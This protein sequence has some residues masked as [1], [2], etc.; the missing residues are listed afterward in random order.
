M[1]TNKLKRFAQDARKKLLEQVAA[2]LEYVLNNDTA[3]L[4]EKAAQVSALKEEL[5]KTRKAQLIERVAYTWFNRLIALRFMDVNGY[6]A[7]DIRIITPKEGHS[8]PELL[9]DAKQ[10]HI[11]EDLKVNTK[12]VFDLLD[13][14]VPSANPQNEAYRMLLIAACNHLHIVLPFLFERINDYT[15]L[16]LPDDLTSEFSI[17]HDAREGMSAEDCQQVEII[18]WLYQFYISEKKDEVFASKAKV[19]KE[20]I[21]AATQLFTPRWIVE[22]MVQNT[23]GKL[24]L[25]NRSNS[26]LRKHMPYFIESA[27][28][29]SEEYL[30]LSSPQELTL[31]DQ[32]CGSGHILV[33]GFELLYRIYEEEGYNPSEIPQ[34]ILAHNLYGFEI[35]E[36]AAQ[37]A[38]MALMMKARSYQRRFFKKGQ[39]PQPHI[40]CFQDLKLDDKQLGT[41]LTSL[42]VKLSDE[43]RHDLGNMRQATNFGSL[44]VPHGGSSEIHT[45]LAT[46]KVQQQPEQADLF[47]QYELLQLKF[48]LQQLQLL[49]K[50][51]ASIVDNPPYMGGGNMDAELSDFVKR[52]YPNSKA[53]LMACFMESGLAMLQPKGFL[54]LV[55]QQSWMFLESYN[56]LRCNIID[57]YFIDTLIQIGFNSFPEL[58][59]KVVQACS[60]V[61]QNE[62]NN[63]R[64]GIY[65][66]L[67]DVEQ[68]ANKKNVFENKLKQNQIYT[69]NQKRFRNIPG[70]PIGYWLNEQVLQV[71]NN[72]KLRKELNS[73]GQLLTGNN[74]RFIR[75][76]WEVAQN[77]I[78]SESDWKLHHKGGEFRKWYGNVSWV[79]KWDKKTRDFYKQNKTA[80]IPK[81][82]LWDLEGITWST[83]T[84]SDVSFRKVLSSESFNKAAPTLVTKNPRI[85]DYIMPILNSK[86]TKYILAVYNPTLN[87]LVQDVENIPIQNNLITNDI[88]KNLYQGC[89]NCSKEEWNSKETS[90]EFTKNELTRIKG[91]DIEQ[92]FD[93]YQL[94]W[95][96]KFFQLHKNEEEINRIVINAYN[97]QNELTPKVELKDVTILQGETSIANGELVFNSD[98]VMAQFVSYAVGCMFGRYSLDVPGLVLANQAETLQ[99]YLRKLEK[100]ELEVS[101][102]PDADNI[103]PVLDDEWFEDDVVGR[104]YEFMK[105]TFGEATF[106]K[107][108]AFVEEC[109]GKDIRKYFVKD[110]YNDHIQRYKKRPI[111][112]LF[113][114]PQGSFNVLIYLHRYT[115]DTVSN[116]LN[117]YLREYQEKLR[118]RREHLVRVEVSGSASEKAK[119]TKEKAR[120]DNVL[121]ELQEYERNIL[122]PLA[123]ERLVLD[124]DNGVLV[125]YNKFGKA[126]K[127]VPGLNDEKAKKQVSEFD[128]VEAEEIV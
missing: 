35:D 80:R 126:I 55:N 17:V 77:R 90:W 97:L 6:Q 40:L 1:N 91:D 115:P 26:A 39:V 118:T 79:V 94:Y 43:L 86:V 89:F 71:F 100:S 11:P 61:L 21:P 42:S 28:H 51:F 124:L 78:G 111:Y 84:S 110:F 25:Q 125:N 15:E 106:A 60:F 75:F 48:A 62:S 120:L 73:E 123:T 117:K 99:D 14:R 3:E 67:N 119:A 24:W 101:F 29:E 68:S 69:V 41:T 92:A 103:I 88:L 107:N 37:L 54:G 45:L 4:R 114:S 49:G 34:L 95:T 121:L 72:E 2:K 83:I 127:L 85:I 113:S 70:T 63:N 109:L 23:V 96:N 56:A 22:Y 66:N 36:R 9:D 82:S 122:Y 58:N 32:A 57:N 13:G 50:K 74:D 33:Y 46:I 38:A 112:W 81:E 16:L 31:L 27:S 20:D 104:F 59:S 128:W 44:I 30:K 108:L 52:K 8:F 93:S 53:D 19:K 10:G 98:E 18:G 12:R 5:D 47:G 65:F 102:L 64:K 116:I 87:Y 76:L 105:V 7:L